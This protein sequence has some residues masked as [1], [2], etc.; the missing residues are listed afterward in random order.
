MCCDHISC[1]VIQ[2]LIEEFP[3]T[4][5]T[6]YIFNEINNDLIEMCKDK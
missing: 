5:L 6:E 1:R 3:T 4:V 2:R